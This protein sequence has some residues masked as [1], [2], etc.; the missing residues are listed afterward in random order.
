[1]KKFDFSAKKAIPFLILGVAI[2]LLLAGITGID[3]IMEAVNQ[4][5]QRIYA[6]AFFVQVL[7]ILVWLTKWRILTKAIGINVRTRRMFPILLSGIFVNTA[8][9]SAK[10][11]G[12]PLRAYMFH[13]LGNVPME[14]SFAS[15]ATDRALDGIPFIAIIFASMAVVI[16]AWELPIYAVVLL[17][18]AAAFVS[19]AVI[20]FLY[21]CF[22]PIPAKGLIF[23]F[24][25]RLRRIIS[26]FRPV[27]YVERKVEEFLE[28]FGEGAKEILGRRKYSV[29]AL[30]L[31]SA[32]WFLTIFRMWLVFLALGEPVSF[33]T[34]GLAVTL[35]LLL[36]AVPIPGGLGVVEGVYVLIFKAAGIPGGVALTA[37]LL[38][39]G[40]SFWFTSL[41]SGGGIAWS[42]LKLS[43]IW[44]ANSSD[45][46]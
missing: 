1:M 39:R 32:Y 8:V 42:G 29:P 11:G 34:L 4:T 27:K 41:F 35:G 38:D 30:S 37:A 22:R 45:V 44:K 9:P 7:T 15:V 20:S 3:R 23:W 16:F 33:G 13:K 6:L 12:E 36:Q 28:G 19:V 5:D 2:I 31:S 24:I 21:V 46:S 10:V 25:R 17:V 26:K 18:I 43:K 40:I 14:K